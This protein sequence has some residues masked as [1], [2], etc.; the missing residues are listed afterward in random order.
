MGEHRWTDEQLAIAGCRDKIIVVEA[1]AGC[2]KTSSLDL[3]ARSHPGDEMLYLAFNKSV[4]EEAKKRFPR[5]VRCQTTHG[6]AYGRFGIQ[7]TKSGKLGNPRATEVQRV[8]SG[9]TAVAAGIV[10]ATVSSFCNSAAPEINEEHA[11]EAL[12]GRDDYPINHVVDAARALWSMMEDTGNVGVKMPHDGYLKLFQL[13]KPRLNQRVILLDEAQDANPV[14]LDIIAQQTHA[15]RVYVGDSHQAIYGFRGA[16]DA[17]SSFEDATR[18]RLTGSFRFGQGL[19]GLATALLHEWG[20]ADFPLIGLGKHQTVFSVDHDRTHAFL[21]RTNG[22]IFERAVFTARSGRPYGFVG[23]IEGYRFDQILDVYYLMSRELHLI[24]DNYIRSFETYDEI[25]RYAEEM[26]DGELKS[27]VKVV[28]EYGS[29]VP[30]LIDLV[31]RNA[32]AFGALETVSPSLISSGMVFFS[33]VHKAKGLEWLDVILGDD[34]VRLE[35]Q[36]QKLGPPKGPSK[37]EVNILYVAMTRAKRGLQLPEQ[38]RGWLSETDQWHLARSASR[39]E[40]PFETEASGTSAVSEV[41]HTPQA[42]VGSS[43]GVRKS[44][45]IVQTR[46]LKEVA[47]EA[48]IDRVNE[49][50]N[51]MFSTLSEMETTLRDHIDDH[52]DTLGGIA[53]PMADWFESKAKAYRVLAERALGQDN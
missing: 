33:T 1:G 32:T 37:E 35:M 40:E 5:N 52:L 25:V 15:R 20:G 23:G 49:A 38:V 18:F 7:Y 30:S 48:R 13:S 6:A 34:F 2:A 17:L 41:N 22:G 26:D 19:A 45:K 28:K 51:V 24:R 10:L 47:A 8:F 31:K 12:N 14:T 16:V 44:V 53:G 9:M 43:R 29:E 39:T 4:Q 50:A 46:P 21:C 36:P 11:L 3:Y 42:D 27:V